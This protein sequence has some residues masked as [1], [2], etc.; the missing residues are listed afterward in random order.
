MVGK[1]D[2]PNDDPFTNNE[3]QFMAAAKTLMSGI[4]VLGKYS[5][6]VNYVG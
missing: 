4:H 6:I 1:Y 5:H 3:R 2:G